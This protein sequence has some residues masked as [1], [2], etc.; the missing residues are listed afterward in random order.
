MSSWFLA[1]LTPSQVLYEFLA[2]VFFLC[3]YCLDKKEDF[4]A[5]NHMVLYSLNNELLITSLYF[6]FPCQKN[7][8][9][10]SKLILS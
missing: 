6:S 8:I 5:A 10:P 7:A 2:L 9:P 3:F 1:V 4:F